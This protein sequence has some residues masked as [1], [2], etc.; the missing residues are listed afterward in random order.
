MKV[1]APIGACVVRHPTV[2]AFFFNHGIDLSERTIFEIDFIW[3]SENIT[4]IADDPTQIQV[5]I[6]V[7]DE[8]LQLVLDERTTVIDHKFFRH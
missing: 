6:S 3:T 8:T 4:Q 2:T 5:A 1:Y 7:E